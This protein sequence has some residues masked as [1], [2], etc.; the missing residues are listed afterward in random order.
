MSGGWP[1]EAV[2]RSNGSD[3]LNAGTDA[4]QRALVAKIT[5][6]ASAI[7][8]SED[9]GEIDDIVVTVGVAAGAVMAV[10]P[11]FNC[12]RSPFPFRSIES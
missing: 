1:A 6:A 12:T 3:G 11:P 5:L 7:T 8:G 10:P 4:S 2:A 9:K